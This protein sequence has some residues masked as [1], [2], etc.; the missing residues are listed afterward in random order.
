ML[1]NEVVKPIEEPL[2]F[3]INQITTPADFNEPRQI[4]LWH[5]KKLLTESDKIDEV[6][7]IPTM[8]SIKFKKRIKEFSAEEQSRLR[9]TIRKEYESINE[10]SIEI[11]ENAEDIKCTQETTENPEISKELDVEAAIERN[12]SVQVST[13]NRI[14]LILQ[15]LIATQTRGSS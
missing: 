15:Q 9:E 4:A 7:L 12:Q 5:P 13:Y 14:R 3:D 10:N 6:D 11:G 8:K 2:I 1:K